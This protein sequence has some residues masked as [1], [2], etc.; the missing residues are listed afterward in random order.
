MDSTISTPTS[1]RYGS[2]VALYK[3]ITLSINSEMNNI[4]FKFEQIC[5]VFFVFACLFV[6]FFAHLEKIVGNY[7]HRQANQRFEEFMT[8][9]YVR[10]AYLV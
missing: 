3:Y 4:L 10:G 5:L 7:S 8:Y 1:N 9:L 2:F 6:C